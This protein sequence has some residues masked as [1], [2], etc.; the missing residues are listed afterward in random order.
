MLALQFLALLLLIL[1]LQLLLLLLLLLALPKCAL[2][3][4]PLLRLLPQ[5]NMSTASNPNLSCHTCCYLWPLLKLLL[6][7]SALLLLRAGATAVAAAAV[8]AVAHRL[9]HCCW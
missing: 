4:T 5:S 9:R 6:L 1:L 8:T 3:I 2:W 7:L